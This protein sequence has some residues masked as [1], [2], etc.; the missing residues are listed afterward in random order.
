MMLEGAPLVHRPAGRIGLELRV[1]VQGGL[2]ILEKIERRRRRFLH[3][4][5]DPARHAADGMARLRCA[6]AACAPS[7]R[8][9][10]VQCAP[11]TPEAYCQEKAAK[12]GSSF[13]YAF[14]FLP[15]PR[16]AAITALYA[17]CR[18][19]DDV[20]DEVTDPSLAAPKL[21]WWRERGRPPVRRRPN[22]P[23]DAR[24]RA[25]RRAYAITRGTARDRRGLEMDLHQTRYLD[26]AGLARY[27]HHV[28][29]V[30]GAVVQHLRR[31]APGSEAYAEKMGLAVQLINII[32]DVGEDARMGRIYLPMDEL[33]RFGVP[34]ADLL[35][36]RRRAFEALMQFQADRAKAIYAE[37]LALL[38]PADRRAQRTGLIM[39]RIYRA[40]STRSSARTSAY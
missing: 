10:A 40:C 1:V 5:D 31:D 35:A 34:A 18:E 15:P 2:R 28:A 33:K 8:R 7:R 14:L 16:R 21:A 27:C 4:A 13:Y 26:F 24:A 39:G 19:V 29:G 37:A 12:S 38:P 11:M 23:G 30:V 36:A 17:F 32:R 3:A 6:A 22:T 20:V 25:A 9:A